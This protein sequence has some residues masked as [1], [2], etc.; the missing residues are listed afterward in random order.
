MKFVIS[1][2]AG[3]PVSPMKP[4]VLLVISLLAVFGIRPQLSARLRVGEHIRAE[5]STQMLKS[6][7]MTIAF[8][9]NANR[10]LERLE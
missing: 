7:H 9:F 3:Y 1:T 8:R 2:L 4:V 10:T 5:H 6:Y